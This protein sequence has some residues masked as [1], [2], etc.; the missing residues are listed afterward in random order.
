MAGGIEIFSVL[1]KKADPSNASAMEKYMKNRFPFLG[2]KAPLRR[3]LSSAFLKGKSKSE[4]DWEFVEECWQRDYREAQYLAMDYLLRLKKILIYEDMPKIKDLVLRKS[5]WDSSDGLDKLI[6]EIGL[7]DT[8]IEPLML[9]WSQEEN[10]WLRRISIIYQRHGKEKTNTCLLRRTIENNLGPQ[11]FFIEKAIGWGLRSYSK[12]DPQW[13]R[14]F[15]E[16]HVARLS[17]L[18]LREGGMY[19]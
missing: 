4:I 3:Q 1:E 8:R 14:D 17:P 15:M 10:L 12:T 6:F 7:N 11:D 13:V 5:W 2:I 9:Q 16:E 19:L 18:S